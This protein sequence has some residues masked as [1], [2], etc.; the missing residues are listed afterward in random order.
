MLLLSAIEVIGAARGETLQCDAQQADEI[1][2][3]GVILVVVPWW[4]RGREGR[5]M[6]DTDDRR[7]A[8]DNRQQSTDDRQQATDG[9]IGLR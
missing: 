5:A 4:G 1:G 6:I 3:R 2:G 7:Q 8:T 9:K